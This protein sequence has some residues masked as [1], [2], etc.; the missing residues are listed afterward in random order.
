MPCLPVACA[1]SGD[2]LNKTK[3]NKIQLLKGSQGTR[4]DMNKKQRES[5][6]KETNNKTKTT[7]KVVFKTKKKDSKK[8]ARHGRQGGKAGNIKGSFFV[9]FKKG[10]AVLCVY[11]LFGLFDP[12]SPLRRGW[13]ARGGW[14]GQG[15]HDCSCCCC[16]CLCLCLWGCWFLVAGGRIHFLW[17]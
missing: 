10:G 12:P 8:K 7:T 11:L 15:G 17:K 1:G 9:F 6:K 2:P 5:N 13:G 4:Q 14:P 3:H 16:W